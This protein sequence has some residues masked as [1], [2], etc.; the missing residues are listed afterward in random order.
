VI[1]SILCNWTGNGVSKLGVA[2]PNAG[3]GLVFSLDSNGNLAFDP[4]TDPVFNFGLATDIIVTGTWTPPAPGT[5]IVSGFRSASA[6]GS[7]GSN[8]VGAGLPSANDSLTTSTTST[9]SPTASAT[10]PNDRLSPTAIDLVFSSERSR[11]R[12]VPAALEPE[13]IDEFF[14]VT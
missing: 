10:L 1:G 13:V 3:G 8:V 4:G 11:P 12:V 2:R 7:S 14:G 9:S 5:S 6:T